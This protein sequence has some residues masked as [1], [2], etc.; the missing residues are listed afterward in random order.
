MDEIVDDSKFIGH[1]LDALEDLN[2]VEWCVCNVLRL[3]NN[4]EFGFWYGSKNSI[5]QSESM[6]I[7]KEW[8]QLN[9]LEKF[10]VIWLYSHVVKKL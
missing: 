7:I 4:V 9:I 1:R 3:T 6:G 2:K 10:D 8:C 5:L